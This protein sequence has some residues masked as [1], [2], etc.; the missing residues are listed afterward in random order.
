[1]VPF[2]ASLATI[3]LFIQFL[4]RSLTSP[5]TIE[6]YISAIRYTHRVNSIPCYFDI[7]NFQ[8]PNFLRAITRKLARLPKRKNPISPHLLS[9][10]ISLLDLRLPVDIVYRAAFCINFF[11]FARK[12]N[13]VPPSV[14][15]FSPHK[16]MTRGHINVIE[17]GLLV[18]MEWSKTNQFRKRL[19]SIPLCSIPNSSLCPVDAYLKMCATIPAPLSSPAFVVPSPSGLVTLTHFSY[20]RKLKSLIKQVGLDPSE[21]S[22]HSFRRGGATFAFASQVSPDL[23]KEHGDWLSDTYQKYLAFDLTERLSVTQSMK[24]HILEL[25]V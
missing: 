1:M 15:D 23:I 2:P 4:S 16:H 10:L 3:K 9:S 24:R 7:E 5:Q 13:I 17:E 19:V 8:V 18:S 6:N 25:N 11:T 12:S 21:F 14:K 22:G 20:V